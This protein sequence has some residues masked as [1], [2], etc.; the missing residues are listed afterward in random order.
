MTGEQV[1]APLKAVLESI[2]FVANAPVELPALARMTGAKQE[3][4]AAA[5]EELAT[6]LQ[7]HGLRIQRTGSQAQLV[8]A[9]E[10]TVYVQRFLGVDED[11]RLSR[12]SLITLTIIAYKQPI[13]RGGV[14]RILGK[15]CDWGIQTLKLRGLVA[16]VGRTSGPGRPYLY[17][18]TFKFLEHFGLEKPEDL[19]PLPE[20]DVKELTAEEG[21]G[22]EE[23]GEGTDG[24]AADEGPVAESDSEPA[25]PTSAPG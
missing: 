20:L 18:T 11:D 6:E 8:T 9:P 17:G 12:S 4:V 24:V 3:E 7:G 2:L 14:E 21:E 23:V 5:L 10:T 1:V 13:T 15:S 25:H 16:E 22:A 19:P